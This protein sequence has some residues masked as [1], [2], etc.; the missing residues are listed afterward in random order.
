MGLVA[1]VVVRSL[2][3]STANGTVYAVLFPIILVKSKITSYL[4]T[5]LASQQQWKINFKLNLC[6]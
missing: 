1:V 4:E 3:S 2:L 5:L 6:H